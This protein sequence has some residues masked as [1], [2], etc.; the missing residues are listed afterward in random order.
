MFPINN[1]EGIEKQE[2]KIEGNHVVALLLIKPSD[3]NADE[4]IS[5]FNYY[6]HLSEKYCS[7]YLLGYSPNFCEKYPDV[8]K[9]TGVNKQEWE[10]SDKCFIEACNELRKR[11][12]HWKYSGE[13]ELIILQ[14]SSA[15]NP[16]YYLN[17]A[18][19]VYIDINYGISKKYIDSF[20]RF[21]ERFTEACK[22]E[23]SALKVISK[24]ERKRIKPRRIIEVTLEHIPK[25][26]KPI[27][28]ILNDHLFLKTYKGK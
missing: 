3:N 25:L 15:T 20:P 28:F 12:K 9:I 14:N 24:E 23:V 18:N 10:Y 19:Y 21:M 2:Q 6:H 22:S 11:L 13:P 1:I 5:N 26:P 4:I 17:F 8:V 16:R 27:V 7:I